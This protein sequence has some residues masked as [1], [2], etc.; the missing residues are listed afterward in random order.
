M[1][2]WVKLLFLTLIMVVKNVISVLKQ[3]IDVGDLMTISFKQQAQSNLAA[4]NITVTLPSSTGAGDAVLVAVGAGAAVPTAWNGNSGAFFCTVT[5]ASGNGQTITYSG[6][7]SFSV[8]QTVTFAT[9][10]SIGTGNTGFNVIN[11]PIIAASGG[12]NGYFTV[13][14]VSA[15]SFTASSTLSGYG[16]VPMN[17]TPSGLGATWVNLGAGVSTLQGYAFYLGY[18]CSAGNTA[19]T[20]SGYSPST[21]NG[22]VLA[23]V[24]GG[25]N[26]YNPIS[27]QSPLLSS[28]T[29]GQ[30]ITISGLSWWPGQLLVGMGETFSW[31]DTPLGT[32]PGT[33]GTW[34][35]IADTPIV[36]PLLSGTGQSKIALIDYLVAPT[37]TSSAN[38][39]SPLP[40]VGQPLDGLV[41]LILNPAIPTAIS[42]TPFSAQA[43]NF[44]LQ[45]STISGV[46]T[47]IL[48]GSVANTGYGA[49]NNNGL[50]FQTDQY[51]SNLP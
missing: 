18:N 15:G 1:T 12:T 4:S 47:V 48:S 31:H 50:V 41:A 19:I 35:G 17:F 37:S 49:V 3:L 5:S 2:S 29:N 13:S 27:Y 7:N 11:T 22:G 39:V 10:G 20:L 26:I 24:F 32:A 33:Y 25:V 36:N 14:G 51:R 42:N 43:P 6:T 30:A 9:L 40:S 45:T 23:A 38:F 28:T 8:G 21:A 46:A 34:N 44:S 16:Q